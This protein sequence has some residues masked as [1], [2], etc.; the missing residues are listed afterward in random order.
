VADESFH[1]EVKNLKSKDVRK[2]KD[3]SMFIEGIYFYGLR[4]SGDVF[5]VTSVIKLSFCYAL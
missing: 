4:D 1:R 5:N 2:N 3:D